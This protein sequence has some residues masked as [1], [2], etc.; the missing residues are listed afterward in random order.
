[1]IKG[2]KLFPFVAS[3][4]WTT[5]ATATSHFPDS[6]MDTFDNFQ[7][8]SSSSYGGIGIVDDTS[9]VYTSNSTSQNYTP[10]DSLE[11]LSIT[12]QD[13][14][15]L[16]NYSTNGHERHHH[17]NDSRMQAQNGFD[18]DFDAVL[19]DLKDE[20]QVELPPHACR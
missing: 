5:A 18:E 11:N 10:V 8:D 9:S 12:D 3:D 7:F 17:I 6:T 16:D 14:S 20:N 2:E 19:D 1:M 13:V 4:A 15:S